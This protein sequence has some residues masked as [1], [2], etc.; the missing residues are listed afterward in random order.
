M[1]S[2]HCVVRYNKK[3]INK[4]SVQYNKQYSIYKKM[5]STERIEMREGYW[6]YYIE[7][8]LKTEVNLKDES[9]N[10]VAHPKS[11]LRFYIFRIS[12]LPIIKAQK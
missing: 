10:V 3:E 12:K 11:N 9:A 4:L 5:L 8:N 1:L 2:H 6:R 7:E